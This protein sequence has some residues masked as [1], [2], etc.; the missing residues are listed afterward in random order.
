MRLIRTPPGISGTRVGYDDGKEMN[1]RVYTMW[2]R[3]LV[4]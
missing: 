3:E 4:E 2:V 1:K